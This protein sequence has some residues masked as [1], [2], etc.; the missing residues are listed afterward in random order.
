MTSC[1][2]RSCTCPLL[3][4]RI[5]SDGQRRMQIPTRQRVVRCTAHASPAIGECNGVLNQE[6]KERKGEGCACMDA[7]MDACMGHKKT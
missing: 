1:R 2:P 5:G 4:E 6:T 3:S 7:C